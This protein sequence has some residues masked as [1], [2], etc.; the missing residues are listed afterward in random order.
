LI[1]SNQNPPSTVS[2]LFLRASSSLD[3]CERANAETRAH[4]VVARARRRP[5][6]SA[7]ACD[8]H[9]AVPRASVRR[10]AT[11]NNDGV[12]LLFGVRPR[13]PES[14]R[15]RCRVRYKGTVKQRYSRSSSLASAKLLRVLPRLTFVTIRR[16]MSQTRARDVRA[17][18]AWKVMGGN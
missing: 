15:D 9:D 4:A 2:R 18:H 8:A 12:C 3:G 1:D 16:R 10:T 17:R 11:T 13:R 6:D 14:S 5:D 7:S